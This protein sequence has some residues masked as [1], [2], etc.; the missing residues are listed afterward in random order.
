MNYGQ[1]FRLALNE[2]PLMAAIAFVLEHRRAAY[3]VFNSNARAY[4]TRYFLRL[5]D[6]ILTDVVR[7]GMSLMAGLTPLVVGHGIRTGIRIAT[8]HPAS[9]G[10]DLAGAGDEGGFV[11]RHPPHRRP[12]GGQYPPGSGKQ[13][14]QWIGSDFEVYCML[15]CR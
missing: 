13:H 7:E 10:S 3:H 11:R 8:D 12:A 14:S 1:S 9:L 2:L 5:G 15:P 4:V 6:F